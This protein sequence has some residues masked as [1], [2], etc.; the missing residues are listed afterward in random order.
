MNRLRTL[1][2]LV[3]VVM[4]CCALPAWRNEIKNREYQIQKTYWLSDWM[5]LLSML[6]FVR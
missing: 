1:R 2:V 5:L 3:V 6:L 4:V